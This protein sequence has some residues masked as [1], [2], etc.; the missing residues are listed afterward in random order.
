V[1]QEEVLLGSKPCWLC[2]PAPLGWASPAEGKPQA[3]S[4]FSI[5][6]LRLS[7]GLM[8]NSG[9]TEATW[10][11]SGWLTVQSGVVW[12]L[13]TL[14]LGSG[15]CW[16][17][18]THLSGRASH[19]FTHTSEPHR[20][21][22]GFYAGEE[23]VSSLV[24]DPAILMDRIRGS[25]TRRPAGAGLQTT[26]TRAS[27]YVALLAEGFRATPRIEQGCSTTTPREHSSHT[28]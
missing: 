2:Y 7:I 25:G 22:S 14:R 3:S 26:L 17:R 24:G 18:E 5:S 12:G 6:K 23:E 16:D 11:S 15:W 10:V 19:T 8:E 21:R 13:T 28:S 27:G 4:G 1:G 20:R 9:F